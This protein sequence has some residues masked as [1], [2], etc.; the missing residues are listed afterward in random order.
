MHT[1]KYSSKLGKRVDK[2]G[3]GCYNTNE[4]SLKG[5]RITISK[6]GIGPKLPNELVNTPGPGKYDPQLKNSKSCSMFWHRPDIRH[7]STLGPGTYNIS[8]QIGEGQFP[9]V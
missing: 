6:R 3:P 7:E 5:P 4:S 2:L 8:K 9:I 1:H